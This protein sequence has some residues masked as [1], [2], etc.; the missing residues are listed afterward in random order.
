MKT[1]RGLKPLL[2]RPRL[3]RMVGGGVASLPSVRSGLVLS[4]TFAG[5]TGKVRS[6]FCDKCTTVTREHDESL[7]SM[8]IHNMSVRGC[9]NCIGKYYWKQSKN[10]TASVDLRVWTQVNGATRIDN[11]DWWLSTKLH[12][13]KCK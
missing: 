11:Q 1:D 5:V 3:S 9:L 6:W 12:S 7:D 10:W 8:A 4:S 2:R 13:W